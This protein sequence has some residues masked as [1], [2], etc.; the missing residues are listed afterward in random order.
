[1]EMQRSSSDA[2]SAPPK[3]RAERNDKEEECS[4]ERCATFLQQTQRGPV[5][6]AGFKK[7]AKC[8]VSLMQRRDVS[9]SH[10]NT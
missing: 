1:M 8:N 3:K 9:K 2:N 10:S 4:T 7:N 5:G 6:S